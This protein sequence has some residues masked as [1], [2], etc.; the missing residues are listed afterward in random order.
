[1]V[2]AGVTTRQRLASLGLV[3]PDTEDATDPFTKAYNE[4]MEG[5]NAGVKSSGAN[6]GAVEQREQKKEG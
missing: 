2:E 3:K 4:L 5:Q 1:M 6:T